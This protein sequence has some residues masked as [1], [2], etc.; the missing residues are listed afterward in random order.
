MVLGVWMAPNGQPI[1]Q[2]EKFRNITEERADRI[3]SFHIH[4]EEAWGY[5]ETTIK[6][7]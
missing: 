3:I 5:Y 6:I 1:T 7:P 4:K 2:T